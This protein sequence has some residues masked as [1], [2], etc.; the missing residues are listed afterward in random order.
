MPSAAP[1]TPTAG[2]LPKVVRRWCSGLSSSEEAIIPTPTTNT[3]KPDPP[4]ADVEPQDQ[5]HQAGGG[6]DR[7]GGIHEIVPA[8]TG[9]DRLPALSR[10]VS[11]IVVPATSRKEGT[12]TRPS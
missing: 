1:A 10:A 4:Q 11:V 5:W 6:D 2:W 3:T 9:A 8:E 7:P 12:R